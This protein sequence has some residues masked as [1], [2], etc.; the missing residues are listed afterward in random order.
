M[1]AGNKI[2]ANTTVFDLI[3]IIMIIIFI[4]VIVGLYNNVFAIP[5]NAQGNSKVN[6]KCIAAN[7]IGTK[8]NCLYLTI[9]ANGST[10]WSS[11][12][13]I[14]NRNLYLQCTKNGFSCRTLHY[15][16]CRTSDSPLTIYLSPVVGLIMTND[17]RIIG[18]VL[19]IIITAR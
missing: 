12:F 14:R 5:I 9:F 3:F 18:S 11:F 2:A 6:S 4:I 17:S 16:C 1:A 10:T 15:Y 13:P 19:F 7:K 8:P